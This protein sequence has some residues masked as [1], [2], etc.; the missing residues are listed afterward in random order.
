MAVG[1]AALGAWENLVPAGKRGGRAFRIERNGLRANPIGPAVGLGHQFGS[2]GGEQDFDPLGILH[3]GQPVEKALQ[4]FFDPTGRIVERIEHVVDA[5]LDFQAEIEPR[6]VLL[7][8][9]VAEDGEGIAPA[10]DHEFM[11]PHALRREFRVPAIVFDQL[12]ADLVPVRL[13]GRSP[14][15]GRRKGVMAVAENICF[16]LHRLS[17]DA[18]DDET[19]LDRPPA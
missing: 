1:I 13:V 8:E 10:F 12:H 19:P 6:L 16:D 15:Q 3:L 2:L 14:K 4:P 7:G 18:F 11:P 9:F 17:D 5:F